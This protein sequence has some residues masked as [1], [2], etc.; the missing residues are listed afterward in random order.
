VRKLGSIN[1]TDLVFS[2]VIPY[3]SDLKGVWYLQ[4]RAPELPNNRNIIDRGG[5][6]YLLLNI[7]V[8]GYSLLFFH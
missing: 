6:N 2:F 7:G 8:R 4:H 5:R 1:P 3:S